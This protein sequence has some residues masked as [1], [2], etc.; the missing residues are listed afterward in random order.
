VK[1]ERKSPCWIII[2]FTTSG[3][4]VQ[5]QHSANVVLDDFLKEKDRRSVYRGNESTIWYAHVAAVGIIARWTRWYDMD[6]AVLS[7][8]LASRLT[9]FGYLWQSIRLMSIL[10]SLERVE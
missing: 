4:H 5:Y 2:D 7:F 9:H 3:D 6:N 8:W 1:L 10:N